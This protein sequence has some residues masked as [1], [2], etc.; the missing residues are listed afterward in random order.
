[1]AV[2]K[3]WSVSHSAGISLS[4]LGKSQW[5]SVGYSV[6]WSKGN[7]QVANCAGSRG[8]TICVVNWRRYQE[9]TVDRSRYNTCSQIP[10]KDSYNIWSPL[11]KSDQHTFYC[12]RGGCKGSGDIWWEDRGNGVHGAA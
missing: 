4:N 3:E 9:Y 6:S 2:G 5:G 12:K 11:T 10:R 1:M 7:S 8:Q